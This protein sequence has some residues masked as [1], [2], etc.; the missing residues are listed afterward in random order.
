MDVG[1]FLHE[2][3][4][5]IRQLYER[6]SVPFVERMR[7]IRDEVPPFEPPYSEDGEP[8]FLEEWGIDDQS[9]HVLGYAC[10]SMLSDT[11]KV[12]F[13]TWDRLIGLP[14]DPPI[15]KI[16]KDRGFVAGYTALFDAR[17][18]VKLADSG[19]DL[20]LLEQIVLLRNRVQ[21]QEHLSLMRPSHSEADLAKMAKPYFLDDHERQSLAENGGDRETAWLMAP[22]VSVTGEQLMGVLDAVD[23]LADW[24]DTALEPFRYGRGQRFDPVV[25]EAT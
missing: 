3:V 7:M 6:S 4:R 20:D 17:L 8:P 5:F 13:A 9:L 10:V 22:S 15:K 14:R 2:R 19:V 11:L 23:R 12:F 18:R 21:H 24:M 25:P 1:W 16:F